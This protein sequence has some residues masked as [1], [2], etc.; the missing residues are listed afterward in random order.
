MTEIQPDPV[1]LRPREPVHRPPAR[2]PVPG[3]IAGLLGAALLI[4]GSVWLAQRD[5]RDVTASSDVPGAAAQRAAEPQGAL[6]ANRPPGRAETTGAAASSE[7]ERSPAP[8]AG[9]PPSNAAPSN[10]APR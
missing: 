7:P 8:D 10:V 1:P 4:G 2:N 6:P 3:R 5:D 9:A